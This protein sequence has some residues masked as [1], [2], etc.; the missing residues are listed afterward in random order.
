MA[1][2]AGHRH[3]HLRQLPTGRALVNT[4]AD[5]HANTDADAESDTNAY[6]NSDACE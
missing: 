4:D 2:R 6:S 1:A 5:S 3:L